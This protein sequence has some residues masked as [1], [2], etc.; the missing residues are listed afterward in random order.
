MQVLLMKPLRVTCRY[1]IPFASIAALGLVFLPNC[2]G[3]N[4]GAPPPPVPFSEDLNKF[5]GLAPELGR[6]MEDLKHDVKL[7]P[8]RRQSPILPLL[9]VGTNYYVALPNYGEVARQA[10][11][12]LNRHLQSSA[13]LREWWRQPNSAGPKVEMFLRQFADISEHLGDEVVVFGEVGSKIRGP[14]LIT[15]VRKPGL[16]KLLEEVWKQNHNA[17]GPAPIFDVQELAATGSSRG[18]QFAVL[19]RPDYIV[20]APDVDALRASNSFLD[21][22]TKEFASAAFGKRVQQAY[23]DGVSTILAADLHAILR[24]GQITNKQNAELLQRSGFGDMEY[25]VWQYKQA[26]DKS[27]SAG[28]LS[29][30]APRRSVAGW[31]APPGKMGSLEFLS[32]QAPLAGAMLLKN[33]GEIYSDIQYLVSASNPQAFAAATP[34]ERMMNISLKDDLL[35]LLTGEIALEMQGLPQ[36][37]PEWKLVLRVSDAERLQATLQK[38]FTVMRIRGAQFEDGGT[39]YYTIVIPSAQQTSEIVYTLID[40][41][42]LLAS[43]RKSAIEAAKLHRSGE[44]LA[45]SSTLQAA[46]PAG[47]SSEVS[48][49]WFEDP[50]AFMGMSLRGQSPEMAELFAKSSLTTAPIVFRGYGEESTIR[51]ISSNAGADPS[52]FLIVAAIALPNLLRA[53]IA[54]NDSSAVATIR[55]INTAEVMYHASYPQ[56]GFARDLASL[57]PDPRG[58][59]FRSSDHA[60]FIDASLGNSACA[61]SAW[62]EKSG[63][64]FNVAAV[65]ESSAAACKD[66]AVTAT[67]ESA[68]TGSKNFCST[69]DG[70]VRFRLGA[71]LTDFVTA[72]ECRR[73]P[74]LP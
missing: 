32:P 47:Y 35:A 31:L 4:A 69:A 30:T 19:V 3:Q 25:A 70:V 68:S 18:E 8:A 2:A 42:L 53:R 17:A 44:S 24:Q 14:V 65:C 49:L 10:L 66:F 11:T 51:G 9:P 29:F 64:K 28:E 39:T 43:S 6:V 61:A 13:V 46:L 55:M 58:K 22:H 36:A 50:A 33:F 56:K 26:L 37:K 71:P 5:P 73:W 38:I 1:F 41:Y 57:G 27:S 60:S 12:T 23:E 48:A 45:T 16:K 21:A 62:C 54:A 63:Y 52:A 15:E 20:A 59:A 72:N 34:F 40:G 67:P 74:P 7:P